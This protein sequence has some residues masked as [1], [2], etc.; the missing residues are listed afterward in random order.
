MSSCVKRGYASIRSASVAP[1]DIGRSRCCTMAPCAARCAARPRPLRFPS[2]S[3]PRHALA[4]RMEKSPTAGCRS[5]RRRRRS[6]HRRPPV[7]TTHSP[8]KAGWPRSR[9]L[10]TAGLPPP[11]ARRPSQRRRTRD[12][13]RTPVSQQGRTIRDARRHR[14]RQNAVTL[15]AMP[16]PR[17]VGIPTSP[18]LRQ[19]A[20]RVRPYL[21]VLP[22]VRRNRRE[23]EGPPAAIEDR[24]VEVLRR[25]ERRRP[26][27]ERPQSVRMQ[28]SFGA[29]AMAGPWMPRPP[30]FVNAP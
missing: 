7:D 10:S 12:A 5:H 26:I 23:S 14:S 27:Q 2:R 21:V 30:N 22:G 6:P 20:G 29:R 19:S 24:R 3:W 17:G 28:A 16:L 13:W 25:V 1:S 8:R 11:P 9:P 4:R 15:L 18:S